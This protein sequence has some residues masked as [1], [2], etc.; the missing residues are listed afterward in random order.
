MKKMNSITVR[1]NLLKI[2]WLISFGFSITLCA[3]VA[4]PGAQGWAADTPG[5]RGGKIIR[6]TNLDASGSGSFAEAVIAVVHELSFLRWG[7]L[8]T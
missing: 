4:F 8:L 1:L 3:Q 7:V 6:V 2:G 5:G